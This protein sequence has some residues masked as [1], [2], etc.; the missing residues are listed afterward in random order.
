MRSTL[1]SGAVSMTTTV[2]GTPAARAAYA[3]PWPALPALIVHTP[4]RAAR[5]RA[6]QHRVRGA[7]HLEGV[8]RLQVLELEPDLAAGFVPGPAQRQQRRLDDD[9]ADALA[10][11]LAARRG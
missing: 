8:D 5:G 10:G 1:V 2:Q 9:A 11:G 4:W 7:A 3:T 6:E